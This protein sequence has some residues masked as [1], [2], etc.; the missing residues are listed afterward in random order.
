MPFLPAP[1]L[2]KKDLQAHLDTYF[3][4]GKLLSYKMLENGIAN[5]LYRIKTTKKRT[6]NNNR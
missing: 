6:L 4:L 5:T 1:K 2:N 3:N